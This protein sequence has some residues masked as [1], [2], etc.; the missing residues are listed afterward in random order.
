MNLKKTLLASALI[1]VAFGTVQTQAADVPAGVKLADTQELVR[2]GG[3]EPATLDPQKV[4]GTPGSHRT[5]ELFEGLYN[6]DG[7]GNLTPGVA[8]SYTTNADNTVYTFNLRKDA[9]WSNG[10]SVTAHDFVFGF[11]R[12]VDPAT[13]S[14]YA[15]YVEIPSIVNA[16]KIINGKANVKNLG[17]K[18]VDDYT[19]E[20]TLERPVPYFVKMTSHQTLFPAPRKTIEKYGSEWVKPGNM[21][22]NG[23]Y[24]LDSWIVNEKMVMVRNDNYWNDAKTVIN[25]VTFLPL[26]NDSADLKRYEAGEI[27]ITWNLPSD[28]FK[29][30]KRESPQEVIITPQLGTYY[31]QFN[32]KVEPYNNPDVRKALSFA[33]NRDVITKY[34]TGVGEQPAY[35]FTPSIVNGFDPATPAYA[36]MTQKERETEAKKLL[37]SAG[38][39]KNNPLAFNLL[40]NTNDGHKRIAI[41]IASMW[42]KTLGV[43]VTLENQEWKT[44]LETRKAGDFQVARAGWIGDYNEASTMLDLLTST[45]GNND[46]KYSNAEYDRLLN[47]AKTMKNPSVNY[48]K[49]EEIAINQDMAVAPIYTYVTKR[50]KK[51]YVG[52]Y[53]PNPEDNIYSRDM[54]IIAH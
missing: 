17:V 18:A 24:K 8:T 4:E 37:Q 33:I 20:V 31:Y 27:D 45:H 13:A 36:K 30:L 35:S 11:Q 44:Y 39:D 22:S 54:Y 5:R 19:F 32:T 48:N 2:G 51:P 41:A 23:A 3:A 49:A 29:R 7:D 43:E 28:H 9:K 10:E 6:L 52:G 42:K 15:W 38:Y 53:Q 50:M 26:E 12:A 40:Y 46:G 16:S 34:V 14:A 25:K 47:E 21:V 1:S